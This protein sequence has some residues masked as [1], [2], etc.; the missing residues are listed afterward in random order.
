MVLPFT[1]SFN[2]NPVIF[3]AVY[4]Y[5]RPSTVLKLIQKI[6]KDLADLKWK[7]QKD[8]AVNDKDTNDGKTFGI[9]HGGIKSLGY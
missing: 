3:P 7:L 5:H 4:R 8:P 9:N 2:Y 1:V 6:A